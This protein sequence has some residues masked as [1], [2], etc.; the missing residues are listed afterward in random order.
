VEALIAQTLETIVGTEN[1][2][3]S[4]KK[5][6]EENTRSI[7][8]KYANCLKNYAQPEA[9]R[10]KTLGFRN[11][12]L[13]DTQFSLKEEQS[14]WNEDEKRHHF[15]SLALFS[16]LEVE[17]RFSGGHYDSR[18]RAAFWRAAEVFSI[19]HGML[20]SAEATL[21][22]ILAAENEAAEAI[23]NESFEETKK[24]RRKIRMMK[25]AAASTIGGFM[26]GFT[27]GVLAPA[28]IPALAS[29]GMGMG[30]TSVSA[31]TSS[32]VIGSL[33]GVAGASMAAKKIGHLTANVS[34]FAFEACNRVAESRV[35]DMMPLTPLTIP[36]GARE[37]IPVEVTV[38]GSM[39]GWELEGACEFGVQYEPFQTSKDAISAAAVSLAVDRALI[40]ADG[41]TVDFDQMA[42]TSPAEN[43]VPM[44]EK[45]EGN[46]SEEGKT[47][48]S[49]LGTEWDYTKKLLNEMIS[50]RNPSKQMQKEDPK[51]GRRCWVL[52]MDSYPLSEVKE[53]G[54]NVFG[55]SMSTFKVRTKRGSSRDTYLCAEPGIYTLLFDNSSAVLRNAYIKYRFAVIPPGTKFIPQWLTDKGEDDKE[56]QIASNK[57]LNDRSLRAPLSLHIVYFVPG[58][59][60]EEHCGYHW[61]GRPCWGAFASQFQNIAEELYPL[62]ECFAV[63]WESVILEDVGNALLGF[64]KSIAASKLTKLA[65]DY[66]I[67]GLLGTVTMPL[68]LLSAVSVFDNLWSTAVNR[69]TS[70]GIVMAEYICNGAQGHRPITLVG[71]SLGARVIFQCLEELG[72]R[73]M[74][75]IVHHAVLVG[76]PCTA[77][78]YRW[79]LASS[80][81]AGRLVNV[82]C[83]NDWILGLLHRTFSQVKHIAGMR[84][85]D[86]P[87]VENINVSTICPTFDGHGSYRKNLDTIL[88]KIH[89]ADSKW[90][91]AS[92]EEETSKTNCTENP[93]ADS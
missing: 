65:M 25:I 26:V 64:L 80:V 42:L 66:V 6:P 77:D 22:T 53:K 1:N 83:E 44:K 41:S 29:V 51:P 58:W 79:R 73:G 46:K 56:T 33:F 78:E 87:R 92:E 24:R 23:E 86:C 9:L 21:A 62:S 91:Y 19:D 57:D 18:S 38:A 75:G 81:V 36:K 55:I 60:V 67:P 11:N 89:I 2:F 72:K 63:R 37:E 49:V 74:R 28:I 61:K 70:A 5:V 7:A 84:K 71:Y 82:Y 16:C 13:D 48:A 85:I 32:A 14:S 68:K 52:G 20:S 59:L 40:K 50:F 54:G 43:S 10:E 34:E 27:G 8:E 3:P 31:T 47:K 88:R 45:V 90:N 69:A 30:L 12:F 35:Q 4:E 17:I 39:L 76:A 93:Q 15:V